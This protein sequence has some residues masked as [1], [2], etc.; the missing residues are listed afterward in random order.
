[1]FRSG[2]RPF[3]MGVFNMPLDQPT[4]YLIRSTPIGANF[5][6]KYVLASYSAGIVAGAQTF[7]D[8]L[9]QFYDSKGDAFSFSPAFIQTITSPANIGIGLDGTTPL[10][11]D[12]PGGTPIK[13]RITGQNPALGQIISV[14]YYGVRG[15]DSPGGF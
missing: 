8:L 1:M 5:R 15:W 2:P 14:T 7:P 11:V 9:F 12:Y 4:N 6:L 10:D 3:L 13:I